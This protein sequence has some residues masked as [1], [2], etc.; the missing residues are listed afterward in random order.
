MWL[1]IPRVVVYLARWDL[2][3]VLFDTAIAAFLV[4][5]LRVNDI[6]IT[7][8]SSKEL[9]NLVVL[10]YTLGVTDNYHYS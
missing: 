9:E 4:Y 3:Y 10:D 6:G 2:S 8:S 1:K 7:L 5:R